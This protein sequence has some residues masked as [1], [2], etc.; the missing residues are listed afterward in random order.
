P[1]SVEST[2]PRDLDVRI[3]WVEGGADEANAKQT[4]LFTE[5]VFPVCSPKL[6][7]G[8]RPLRD[9]AALAKLTLLHKHS[10]AAGEWSWP[11]WLQ[12]LGIDPA[13]HQTKELQL[14]EMGLVLSAAIQGAGVALSRSLLVHDALRAGRLVF[15]L[16]RFQPMVSSKRHVARWPTANVGDE[17]V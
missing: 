2:L 16:D 15:A 1:V 5:Q 9:P 8:G 4:P 6:L 10:G 17:D 11:V 12:R 7:P 14:A 3:L 13:R